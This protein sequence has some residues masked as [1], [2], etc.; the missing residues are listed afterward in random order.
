MAAVTVLP[1]PHSLICIRSFQWS[2]LAH[3]SSFIDGSLRLCALALFVV[4]V[5]WLDCFNIYFVNTLG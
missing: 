1:F 2:G 4:Y 5:Y 3:F